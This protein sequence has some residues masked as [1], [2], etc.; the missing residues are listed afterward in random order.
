MMG[1][2]GG[3]CLGSYL[4]NVVRNVF[5]E[6]IKWRLAQP[7]VSHANGSRGFM[8]DEMPAILWF[9]LVSAGGTTSSLSSCSPDWVLLPAEQEI[10]CSETGIAVVD[11]S[12][13][14]G[15]LSLLLYLQCLGHVFEGIG[16]I[17]SNIC[18][19]EFSWT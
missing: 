4:E 1:G 6:T 9:I 13:V 18:S 19:S 3:I 7:G 14:F 12:S 2:W 11:C 5:T 17:N 10:V 8:A 16:P 15:C